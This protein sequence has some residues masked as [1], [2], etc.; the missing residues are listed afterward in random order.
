MWS[1]LIEEGTNGVV[2]QFL[3]NNSFVLIALWGLVIMVLRYRAQKTETL[4]DD[5]LVDQI[6][7]TVTGWFNRAVQKKT[8]GNL[9]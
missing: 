8:M 5:E 7:S 4:A 1:W 2:L 9:K 3:D 6:D